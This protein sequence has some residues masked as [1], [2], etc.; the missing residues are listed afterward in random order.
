MGKVMYGLKTCMYR[1]QTLRLVVRGSRRK[2]GTNVIDNGVQAT[3][4]DA[5]SADRAKNMRTNCCFPKFWW[6]AHENETH[7]LA[8]S[9]I[10]LANFPP[11]Y[12]ACPVPPFRSQTPARPGPGPRSPI[13]SG[14]VGITYGIND[15]N[16]PF[17]NETFVIDWR[18]WS[19]SF[20]SVVPPTACGPVPAA[21]GKS[22]ECAST[23]VSRFG[24][25]PISS[26]S[27]NRLQPDNW[28][29]TSACVKSPQHIN[30]YTK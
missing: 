5:D 14:L 23:V 29:W 10:S 20:R 27:S 22:P 3:T 11:K 13:V 16:C 15:N 9:G 25:P 17:G 28:W 12:F 30:K 7:V 19:S 4:G 2:L 1:Q 6:I 21:R 8:L 24:L 26:R 18:K